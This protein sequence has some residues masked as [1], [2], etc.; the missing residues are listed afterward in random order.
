MYKNIP[1]LTGWLLLDWILLLLFFF[2]LN[3]FFWD[4]HWS[5]FSGGGLHVTKHTLLCSFPTSKRNFP[6]NSCLKNNSDDVISAMGCFSFAPETSDETSENII[7]AFINNENNTSYFNHLLSLDEYLV[8]FFWQTLV[9]Y[10][11]LWGFC[12]FYISPQ[13]KLQASV[14]SDLWNCE[15]WFFAFLGHS[16]DQIH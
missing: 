7:C 14:R 16:I 8:Q 15:S 2:N 1:P 6:E 9:P 4:M 5:L 12:W 10:S 13:S 11:P 3:T